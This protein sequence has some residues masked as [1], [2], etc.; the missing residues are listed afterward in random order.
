VLSPGGDVA[1]TEID[2]RGDTGPSVRAEPH[3]EAV[4]RLSHL[5]VEDVYPLSGIQQ[6][7]LFHALASDAGDVY[8]VQQRIEISGS[9][10]AATFLEAWTHVVRRHPALRTAFAWRHDGP[11]VQIVCRD[12]E[13]VVDVVDL[14]GEP[15]ADEIVERCFV[16]DRSRR[17]QLD[18]PPLMR[19][20]LFRLAGDRHVMMWTQHHLLQDAWSS[21]N[22]LTEVFAAYEDLRSGTTPDLPAVRPF[23]DYIAWLQQQPSEPLERYW[24]TAL[25]GFDT[26]TRIA[27]LGDELGDDE[28]MRRFRSL[29]DDLSH[30]LR[31]LG[32]S[33]GLSVNTILMGAFAVALGRYTSATDVAFGIVASG[34]PPTIDGVEQMIGMFIN[35]LVLRVPVVPHQDTASWLAD[36]QTRQA[37]VLEHEHS[38]LADVQAWSGLGAGTTLTDVLFAY[39]SFGDE[40][41]SPSGELTYATVDGFGRTSFPFS[42]TIESAD[43]IT[44]GLEFVPAAMGANEA[45][46][47]LEHLATLVGSIVATPDSVVGSL[48]MLNSDELAQLEDFNDTDAA[49]P[50]G[51]VDDAISRQIS[52]RPDEPAVVMDDRI[53]TYRQLGEAADAI[54][55]DIVRTG[56]FGI[57]TVAVLLPRSPEMVAAMIGS[58]RA[59]AAYIPIDRH[60]P[61]LRIR[62][63]LEDSGA[64]VVVTSPELRGLVADVVPVVQVPGG[65]D[66]LGLDL[67]IP[68][69]ADD[70]A[71]IMYTSGSTG[72][73]KGVVVSHGALSEYVAWAASVYADD[74]PVTFPLY[75]SPGFDLT[76]TSIYVPLVTG[77]TVV[78][79]PDDD[80]RD[81]AVLDVF[82][83]DAV[84]VVKLTPSHLALLDDDALDVRRIRA[85]I[86]GGEDLRTDL[87]SRVHHASRGSIVVFNEYGPTE[88]TVGCM[89]HRYDPAV[90]DGGS[91]PIGR[92]AANA[93]IHV[94]APDGSPVPAG[95]DGEIHVAGAGLA[96]GYLGRPDLTR[97]SFL[98]DPARTG[99]RMYRT[100]DIARWCRP[101]VLE[102]GGRIDEQVKLRGNRIEPGEI[103]ASLVEHP[104][105]VAAAVTIREPAP[106]DRR[107]VAFYVPSPATTVNITDVRA[108]LAAR[109]P[110]HMVPRH[111]VALSQLPLSPNGKLDRDALPQTVGEVSTTATFVEPRTDAERLVARQA[112]RLLGV[113]QVGMGDNFFDLGGHSVL[114]MQLITR[115]RDETGERIS[116]R[117]V[118]LDTLEQVAAQL[119]ATTEAH[120]SQP[121]TG[122]PAGFATGRRA[123]GVDTSAFYFGDTT[124]PLFGMYHVPTGVDRGRAVLLCAP[125]G[126]EYMR[127]H[128][129]IRTVA[130]L[131]AEDGF[132]VLRFDY[133]G[134]GDSAGAGREATMDRWIDDIATAATELSASSGVAEVSLVGVR[135]GGTLAALACL[136]RLAA[137]SLVLWDPVVS[138]S[139]YLETLERMHAEMLDGRTGKVTAEMIGDELLGFPFPPHRR[140]SLAGIELGTSHWP[141]VP[142]RIVTSAESREYRHLASAAGANVAVDVVEDVGGWDDLASAQA[143][144]LPKRIPR[145]IVATIGTMS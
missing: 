70:P 79:Y 122:R 59:G 90:D 29:S 127:T 63:M 42:V 80:A 5:G 113:D 53:V 9:L 109:L 65:D 40:G 129:A 144:L 34:R 32:R 61:P 97:S 98:Q 2:Y 68:S 116:P 137:A 78:V 58:M 45:E 131:L 104:S 31:D 37:E 112:G 74:E 50:P 55:A 26:P 6:G 25:D 4:A 10:D 77:G 35:T 133:T 22:V 7:M 136:R 138:G 93:R 60:L 111:L 28:P 16:A 41:S 87:A 105:V 72:A 14:T 132:H 101:G 139:Q 99:T 142:T 140:E 33:R 123:T 91:V 13:P 30:R 24:R 8:T 23:S 85:L 141:D 48:N 82:A 121:Q 73:P 69:A 107:L 47:F 51:T 103:E 115:L 128:W 66:E 143:A 130:R 81:L 49:P 120:T 106:G 86:V 119:S 27:K 15:V 125:L 124:R 57:R 135:L 19:I 36:L 76:V 83:D 20:T 43:A 75:T 11:A 145:H 38:A 62:Y 95:V 44:L 88:A 71:Y 67:E 100:G 118:L 94:L 84:D 89:L 64:D 17:F 12:V 108:H 21:S 96:D 39:W 56:G 54:A 110:D 52:L 117:V 126:W 18:E 46:R 92:P 134:T 1:T 3:A 102:Y 114:A